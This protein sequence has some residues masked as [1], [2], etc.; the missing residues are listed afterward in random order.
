V[1]DPKHLKTY[2]TVGGPDLLC[3][4][5]GK[6]AQEVLKRMEREAT[7]SYQTLTL[8]E[9]DAANVL[10]LNGTLVHRSIDEIPQSFKVIFSPVPD[11]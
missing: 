7:F 8:P 3:V 5:A 11:L 2:I 4:G 6:E 1:P 9:D 10:Y